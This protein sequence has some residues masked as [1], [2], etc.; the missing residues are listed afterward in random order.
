MTETKADILCV[1]IGRVVVLPEYRNQHLGSMVI[2]EAEKWIA[3]LGYNEIRIDSRVV[4][5]GFYEKL[6]YSR[7]DNEI[8][9]SW[10]FECVKMN[11]KL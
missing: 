6:G 10:S 7:M 9:K 2:R 5:S 11:K 4:A 8:I 1:M 3:E